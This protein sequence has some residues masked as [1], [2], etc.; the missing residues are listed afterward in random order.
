M[1]DTSQGPGW[2]L[3]S[4]GKYYPPESATWSSP[5]VASALEP[6]SAAWLKWVAG[7]LGLLLLLGTIVAVSARSGGED[8]RTQGATSTAVEG[9]T[10][11]SAQVA[12]T[13]KPKMHFTND[14]Y[15]RLATDPDEFEGATVDVVG[16]IFTA[17][18]VSG[19]TKAFQMFVDPRNSEWNTVV[20]IANPGLAVKQ[21]DYVRVTGSVAGALGGENAFGGNVSGV[22]VVA[23]KVDIVDGLA[24][25]PKA[26]R[27]ASGAASTQHGLTVT[28]EKVEFAASETRFFVKITNGTRTKASFYSFNA[29][30]TQGA[31]QFDPEHAFGYDYPEPQSEILPGVVTSGVI[32]FPA[33]GPGKTTFHLEARTDNYMQDFQPFTFVTG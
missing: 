4:D 3:A 29:K 22:S 1:S 6:Q 18:E 20:A 25:A 32:V 23:D 24:L 30:A 11:T 8:V 15:A 7:G 10:A 33:V 17:P 16:K 13:A 31:Q 19:S 9:V 27:T 21:G 26:A 12:T 28:M 14:N 5:P 2:W